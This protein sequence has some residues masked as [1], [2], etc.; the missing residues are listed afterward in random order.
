MI[1]YA[2]SL[3]DCLSK[4]WKIEE[5]DFSQLVSEQEFCESHYQKS[6]KRGKSG[7]QI[8]EMSIREEEHREIRLHQIFCRLNR[9]PTMKS[10]YREFINEYEQLNH[11]KKA[12]EDS[13]SLTYLCLINF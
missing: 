4:F 10:L 8:I 3:D 6:Y 2:E 9:D 7:R 11:T 13:D 1:S 12:V 5:I